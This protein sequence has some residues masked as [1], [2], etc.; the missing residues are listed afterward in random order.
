M[1]NMEAQ[2]E[3]IV[4]NK[5][6]DH[7]LTMMKQNMT[8]MM[9]KGK[10]T[11]RPRAPSSN[12]FTNMASSS[13]STGGSGGGSGG[14]GGFSLASPTTSSTELTETIIKTTEEEEDMANC[15]I[16]L[17][18]GGL[19]NGGLSSP[20][21][22]FQAAEK[23][24]A[25]GSTNTTSIYQCKTCNRC[26]QSFQALGGHRASHKKPKT[27]ANNNMNIINA[28]HQVKENNNKQTLSFQVGVMDDHDHHQQLIINGNS[29]S[30]ALS[31]QISNSN[32]NVKMNSKV[33]KV[34]ECSICGAE[35]NSGQALGGHMRRH[36]TTPFNNNAQTTSFTSSTT[37]TATHDH[38][39]EKLKNNNTTTTMAMVMKKKPRHVLELDLNLPAPD[40]DHRRETKFPFN[41]AA[42][43]QV[44]VFSASPLVDCHY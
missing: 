37:T 39:H 9:I 4:H 21:N 35:F 11:K 10:R 13:S 18:Q 38:D 3:L 36:R 25:C 23:M 1:T 44:I 6:H 12:L 34:H 32:N 7:D 29:T 14:G 22:E 5:D 41:A 20:E 40:E 26:F 42:K 33:P 17:A 24:A 27:T 19:H 8:M 31:L 16:L 15:L 30:T 43:E 28:D 2:E